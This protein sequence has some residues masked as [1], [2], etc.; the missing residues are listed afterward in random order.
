MI[1]ITLMRKYSFKPKSISDSASSKLN[2]GSIILNMRINSDFI[3]ESANP[4][5]QVQSSILDNKVT[6]KVVNDVIGPYLSL[7]Q[8]ATNLITNIIETSSPIKEKFM[9]LTE[10]YDKAMN[11]LHFTIAFA[12]DEQRRIDEEVLANLNNMVKMINVN[13]LLNMTYIDG[14]HFGVISKAT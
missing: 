10:G 3:I 11:D 12:N 8:T 2:K 9:E 5:N 6:I 4:Q 13:E 14:D 1:R 7:I